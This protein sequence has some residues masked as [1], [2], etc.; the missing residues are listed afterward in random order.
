MCD[1]PG[2]SC[3]EVIVVS[4]DEWGRIQKD[5]ALFIT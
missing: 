1:T 4:D 2:K 5:G 3:K